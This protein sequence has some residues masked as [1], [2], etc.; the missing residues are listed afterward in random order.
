MNY[1]KMR[2][3]GEKVEIR[4]LEKNDRLPLGLLLTADPSE[5]LIQDY[6]RRGTTYAC[7]ESDLIIGVYVL[8]PT[9]P[10]TMELVNIAVDE[11]WQ[12]RGIGKKMIIH[13]IGEARKGGARTLEVGTGNSSVGQLALYQKCGFRIVSID[14]DFFIRHYEE[15]IWENGIRCR[16]MIRLSLD[17]DE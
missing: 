16:D 9:R 17:L 15:E 13:A 1:D 7:S 10:E 11:G 4:E 2:E 6:T 8:M 3:G 14:H 12:G 5:K